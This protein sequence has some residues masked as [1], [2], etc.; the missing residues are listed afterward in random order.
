[1][2]ESGQGRRRGRGSRSLTVALLLLGL[3]ACN[4]RT[5]PPNVK[6]AAPPSDAATADIPAI[7][8]AIASDAASAADENREPAMAGLPGTLWYVEDLS[9]V[10]LACARDGAWESIGSGT[11]QLF[12]SAHALPDRRIVAIAS[13]GDGRPGGE[14][15]AL[16][17]C[18][19]PYDKRVSRVGPTATQ[20]RDPTVDPRGKWIVVAANL[21]GHSELYRID[22]PANKFVRLT[23][24][25]E[26]NFHPAVMGRDAIAFASSRDGDSEIYRMPVRGGKATRLTAFHKDDWYP[27]PSPDG[28]QLAFLSDRE[29][30]PRIFVMSPT[31][32][33]IRRLTKHDDK[34]IDELDPVWS[35]SSKHLAYVVERGARRRVIVHELATAIEREVT[36]SGANDA[37]PQWS[38]DGEW[39][40]TVRT[41]DGRVDL[42][43]SPI[44][45]RAAASP[46]LV[47]GAIRITDNATVERLPRWQGI[48]PD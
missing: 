2:G 15:L 23:D 48:S 7:D 42:Y 8:A 22:L 25:K 45:A 37:E 17:A 41:R 20:V 9:L 44:S 39:L 10:Q 32:T 35:P 34:T 46:Q 5:T 24:N 43:A 1:M 11:T 4:E 3:V 31:G 36:P 21:E 40:V 26:G 19:H 38:P 28:K 6:V 14:Q 29:G 16:V 30:K 12:P 27:T 47:G 18:G 33:Q 13:S